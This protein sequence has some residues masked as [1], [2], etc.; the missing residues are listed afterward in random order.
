MKIPNLQMLLQYICRAG[1]EHHVALNL[2]QKADSIAEALDTYM[3]WEVY[4]HR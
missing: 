4:R 3:D 2:S 1:F